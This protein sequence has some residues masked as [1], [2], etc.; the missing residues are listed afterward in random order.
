M[1]RAYGERWD[2][3]IDDR[4]VADERSFY[5]GSGSLRGEAGHLGW[6]V[7]HYFRRPPTGYVQTIATGRSRIHNPHLAE[8][9]EVI[10]TLTRDPLWDRRRLATIVRFQIGYYDGLLRAA[11]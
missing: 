8:Y 5:A 2:A 10:K 7:G 4:G 11:R 1:D 6:R 3:A 9:Y